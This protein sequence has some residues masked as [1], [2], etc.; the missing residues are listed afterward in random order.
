MAFLLL[1]GVVGLVVGMIMIGYVWANWD[2]LGP[3]S[4]PESDPEPSDGGPVD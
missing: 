4:T 1:L 3:V 2:E